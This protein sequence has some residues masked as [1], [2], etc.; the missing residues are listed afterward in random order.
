MN[1]PSGR[2]TPPGLLFAGIGCLVLGLFALCT[3]GW[4]IA[5]YA[6]MQSFD[7]GAMQADGEA[8]ALMDSQM[9]MMRQ[10][11]LS[12]G[13]GLIVA[14]VLLVVGTLILAKRPSARFAPAGLGFAAFV[15]LLQVGLSVWMYLQMTQMMER[16]MAGMGGGDAFG[17]GVAGLAIGIP[18]VWSLA[19]VGFFVW[20]AYYVSKPETRELFRAPERLGPRGD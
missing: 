1:E 9:N 13:V 20:S 12:A 8:S 17:S 16:E 6:M 11:A 10:A 4:G 14:F 7:L 2:A 3:Q 15:E 5:S 18:A 19:K